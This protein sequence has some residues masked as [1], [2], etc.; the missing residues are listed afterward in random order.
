VDLA[1]EVIAVCGADRSGKTVFTRVFRRETFAA[2]AVQL[3]PCVF[4]LEACGAAHHWARWLTSHGHTPQLMAAE[5]VKPFRKSRAA[6]NDRND[7][8]AVLTAVRQPNMRFVAVKSI[9]QQACLSWHRLRQG[10]NEERTALINRLRGLLGEFGVWRGRSAEVLTRALP[11]LE[12]DEA[13]PLLVRRL[14]GQARPH[15]A[16]LDEA[17][18]VCEVEIKSHIKTNAA[19]RRITAITG[20]GPLTAA[21]VLA[22]VTDAR[23]FKNGRQF[24]AW[25]GL[26]P[27]QDS[28]GQNPAGPH[29]QARRHLPARLAHPGRALGLQVAL[30]KEPLRRTRLQSWIVQLHARVGYHKTLVAIAN[31][32]ARMIWAILAKG[33][34]YDPD[35]WR[36]WTRTAPSTP[37]AMCGVT[38]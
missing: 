6:K 26:V 10:F 24:A 9:E 38:P 15:L 34:A 3:P 20:V 21:A 2:W 13:L 29:H 7:A 16:R 35:A 25:Q 14:L 18:T 1:K 36:R 11:V 4:G 28:S 33:E 17:I 37:P 19:A 8:E 30:T 31:K 5:F 23:D 32:H 27:S 22:T 12:Q